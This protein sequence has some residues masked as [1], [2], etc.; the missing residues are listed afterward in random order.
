MGTEVG[1]RIRRESRER[2]VADFMM[3]NAFVAG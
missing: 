1:V 2:A 3:A